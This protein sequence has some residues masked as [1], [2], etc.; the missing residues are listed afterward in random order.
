MA[1]DLNV[2]SYRPEGSDYA[3][4]FGGADPVM[5]VKPGDVLEL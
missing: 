3:W 4:T 2:I 5:T 1:T